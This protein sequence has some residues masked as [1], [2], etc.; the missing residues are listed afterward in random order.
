[1]EDFCDNTL[2]TLC[3][4]VDLITT[5][6]GEL[7]KSSKKI[8]A[9]AMGIDYGVESEDFLGDRQRVGDQNCLTEHL[10]RM[11]GDIERQ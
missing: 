8:N 7:I 5:S 2:I 1:M 10:V 3:F 9:P 6:L 11:R 4:H